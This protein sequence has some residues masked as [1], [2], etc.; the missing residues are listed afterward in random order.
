LDQSMKAKM[1][2]RLT[3]HCNPE[4]GWTLRTVGL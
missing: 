2:W 3:W 4:G 1:E